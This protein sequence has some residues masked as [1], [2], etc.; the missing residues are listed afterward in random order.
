MGNQFNAVHGL[1]LDWSQTGGNGDLFYSTREQ[2]V[3]NVQ[4]HQIV[5]SSKT[6]FGEFI[7]ISLHPNM[8]DLLQTFF[9]MWEFSDDNYLSGGLTQQPGYKGDDTYQRS[10]AQVLG[11]P[12]EYFYTHSF[13][14]LRFWKHLSTTSITS[15]SIS[16]QFLLELHMANTTG[17]PDNLVNLFS[18]YGTHYVSEYQTGNLL[19]QIIVYEPEFFAVVNQEFPD[20]ED[21]RNG[22]DGDYFRQ[23]TKL[24]E[25]H[26][27]DVS[28]GFSTHIGELLVA[29]Q[30][31]ALNDLI[32]LLNDPT[33]DVNPSILMFMENFTLVTLAEELTQSIQSRIVF[34]SIHQ[35]IPDRDLM[36]KSSWE[37]VLRGATYHK[38]GT[39]GSPYFEQRFPPSVEN[40]YSTFN[41]NLVTS[42][43]TAYTA[44]VQMN[45]DLK[46]LGQVLN[47][48]YIT[49]LYIFADVLEIS[50]GSTLSVPG[51]NTVYLVC[52]QFIAHS[53]ANSV[54]EILIGSQHSKPTIKI[55]ADSFIGVLRVTYVQA[56]LEHESYINGSVFTLTPDP[57]HEN[58]T[59]VT[60]VPEKELKVPN[61][62]T[63]PELYE[64]ENSTEFWEE[65][66]PQ[67]FEQSMEIALVSSENILNLRADTYSLRT[68]NKVL[69]WIIKT[70]SQGGNETS[71]INSDLEMVLGRAHLLLKT[72]HPQYARLIVPKL[73]FPQYQDLYESLLDQVKTYE[74]KLADITEEI[75]QRKATETIISGQEVLNENIKQI[76]EFLVEQ[77]ETSIQY[78]KDVTEY[79]SQIVEMKTI[80]LIDIQAEAQTLLNDTLE[81]SEEVE[82]AGDALDAALISWQDR[83]AA[84]AMFAVIQ[85][86]GG[87]FTGV[88]NL[89]GS[90]KESPSTKGIKK[91]AEKVDHVTHII[92]Q[93]SYLYS[94][95]YDLKNN[96]AS[97][98]RYFEN[99]PVTVFDEDDF[100]TDIEW[101]DFVI[102]VTSYTEV[103]GFL[104]SQVAGEALDF[105]SASKMLATRGRAYLSAGRKA[106]ELQYEIL[107]NLMQ[108]EMSSRQVARLEKLKETMALDELT[109]HQTNTTNLLE[110]GN[111]LQMQENDVQAK[112]AQSF[113]TMDAAL[114]YYYM[115]A[116][117]AI[118][119]YDTLAVQQAASQQINNAIYALE[120]VDSPPHDLASP[121]VYTIPMVPVRKLRRKE[122]FHN[123]VSLTT[124]SFRDYARVRIIEVR[125]YISDSV[126]TDTGKL[127]INGKTTGDDFQDRDL[128]R[129]TK[130]YTSYPKEY[131]FVYRYETGEIVVGN[132]PGQG[133]ENTWIMMTPFSEWVFTIPDVSTN[134]GFTFTRPLTDLHIEFF[135]NVVYEPSPVPIGFFSST[136]ASL[137][138]V[139]HGRSVISGWDAVLA[140]DA[141]SINNLWQ[142]KYESEEEDGFIH[143]FSTGWIF[144]ESDW[145]IRMKQLNAT[146]APPRIQ[147]IQN[148]ENRVRLDMNI[149]SGTLQECEYDKDDE[150]LEGCSN[151]TIPA[152]EGWIYAIMDISKFQGNVSQDQ[153]VIA[154]DFCDAI[155]TVDV[156]GITAEEAYKFEQVLEVYFKENVNKGSY[157]LSIIDYIT[158][159]TPVSLQPDV[160]YFQTGGF[161][162]DEYTT[163]LGVLHLFI[164]T[165]SPG[166]TADE[167]T[168]RDFSVLSIHE[169]VIPIGYGSALFISNRIMFEDFLLPEFTVQ[170]PELST[171]LGYADDPPCSEYCAIILKS[172]V[173]SANWDVED[174]LHEDYT[175]IIVEYTLRVPAYTFHVAGSE[176]GNL[177]LSWSTSWN[178]DV[179]YE[180]TECPPWCGMPIP[181]S[182]EINFIMDGREDSQPAIDENSTVYFPPLSFDTNPL[183]YEV[184]DEEAYVR[185]ACDA[186][187]V[188]ANDA[189][190]NVVFKVPNISAFALTNLIFPYAKVIH[191]QQV[192][193]P[194][195]LLLL[196]NIT[197][198]YVP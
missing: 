153:G 101:E 96:I 77:V 124:P 180:W 156:E 43:A 193:I 50:A 49:D 170:I 175:T 163:G 147:F 13:A 68:A 120:S 21:H 181:Y 148:N 197:Q 131:R 173:E 12:V 115:Q 37:R 74:E 75:N 48:E 59:S 161:L 107:I 117:T 198:D 57:D 7:H 185:F 27:G 25:E 143:D 145:S 51:T 86:V 70:L 177:E 141:E 90:L 165:H 24:H 114:Q 158:G 194:G 6:M 121:I 28:T 118:T 62:S 171:T 55:V 123:R 18:K 34:K 82:A 164:K 188:L 112:L 106:S 169:R 182:P 183:G 167:T 140:V 176:V 20:D 67:S 102:E 152:N 81:M 142:Q 89:V 179:Y 129:N 134:A 192:Y 187:I 105:R 79:H 41:P 138:E 9:D 110:V 97:L 61:Y 71:Y 16:E 155:M 53:R 80:E 40:F 127:Y 132:R 5:N 98:N 64:M 65:W 119:S 191:L 11:I 88:G 154:L 30:D 76:G 69:R 150:E 130:H 139:M 58:I 35:R 128:N 56:N 52:R 190:N 78:Q 122:G 100:P 151:F 195:D 196:G 85:V 144:E 73:T 3:I 60:T 184:I 1:K 93:V 36:T 95:M 17:N 149:T 14:L 23:Y 172:S 31:P 32:P 168:P 83:M 126:S 15:A 135:L 99:M 159:E 166:S 45:F 137:V 111:I 44:I 103:P 54:P 186:G 38:F 125:F 174:G 10:L 146:L 47:P 136:P 92:E 87:L 46:D 22:P 116:P 33:Y 94:N 63:L 2:G 104:P 162:V 26:E 178:Q 160:F 39:T 19:Y 133:F 72:T 66:L 157:E 113:L 42:T 108:A 29:T 4:G 8:A 84:E 189:L 109:E 91:V